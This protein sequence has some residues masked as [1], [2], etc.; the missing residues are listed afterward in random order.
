MTLQRVVSAHAAAAAAAVLV[1][2]RLE[3]V[4]SHANSR[5]AGEFMH[6]V[7]RPGQA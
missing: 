1:I 2:R 7:P 3:S 6:R 4:K 5:Q